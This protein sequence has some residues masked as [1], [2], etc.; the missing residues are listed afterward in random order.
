[1]YYNKGKYT[2]RG[3]LRG[4]F[5]MVKNIN[6]QEFNNEVIEE[7]GVV[8]VDFGQHGVNVQNDCSS[9]RGVIIRNK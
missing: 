4:D 7:N 9:Y 2:P 1:M 5:T 3:K 8:V 6:E